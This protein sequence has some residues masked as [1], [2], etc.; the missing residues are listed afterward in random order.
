MDQRE[1]LDSFDEALNSAFDGRQAQINT[2]GPGI[3]QSFNADAIT[4]VVQPAIKGNVRAPDG[5]VIQVALPLLL[6]C[7]VVF[8]RGGGVSL[9]FPLAGDDEC[10]VVFSQRCI[11]AWWSA[12]GIQAQAEFRMHDLS[13]GF[14]IPGPYSQPEKIANISTVSAQF[15]SNDGSTFVDLNPTTQKVTITAPGGFF[16]NAPMSGFSGMVVI[17]GLLSWL[18][19]MTGTIASG[20]ASTITG[21]VAFIGSITSNGHAIDSTHQHTNSGGT[22][23]GGPP[24]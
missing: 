24:Q 17:Q 19:G 7:P 15:R 2:A 23:L 5:S 20:V 12:G 1:R 9:T 11:D 8:P 4:A 22:G 3:I 13:D 6:D 18:A 21:A 14:A 16:V 10:L